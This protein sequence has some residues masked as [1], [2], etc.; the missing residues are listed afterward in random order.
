MSATL[1]EMIC[2]AQPFCSPQ[3]GRALRHRPQ[4]DCI[5]TFASGSELREMLGAL[6]R[7]LPCRP[8]GWSVFSGGIRWIYGRLPGR[9]G[10]VR[11]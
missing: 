8:A 2:Q 5:R 6:G 7:I 3:D 10:D 4:W 9:E 1:T 11:I